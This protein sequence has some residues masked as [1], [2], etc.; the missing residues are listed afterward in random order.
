MADAKLI[1]SLL[2]DARYGVE[3]W[4]DAATWSDEPVSKTR[5]RLARINAEIARRNTQWYVSADGWLR[6]VSWR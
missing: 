1:D 6:K 2:R 4:L 3:F 5:L